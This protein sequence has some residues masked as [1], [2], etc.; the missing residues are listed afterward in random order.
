MSWSALKN[1]KPWW[2]WQLFS[3]VTNVPRAVWK[4]WKYLMRS[5]PA[6]LKSR[7][8]LMVSKNH[9]SSCSRMKPTITQRKLSPLV[10]PQPVSEVPFVT[11]CQGVLMFI[12]RCG[13][14]ERA[15]LRH[16]SRRHVLVNC[17]N[18]SFRRQRLMVILPTEIK[19]VL[20]QLMSVSISTQAL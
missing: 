9:G 1:R 14:Q 15:I 8:T 5:M 20:Q 11:H 4:I 7:L 3:V 12:R 13:S 19:S 6:R 2:I 17:R 10:E 18:K 16:R